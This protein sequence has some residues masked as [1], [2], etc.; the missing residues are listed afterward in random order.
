MV[1][2]PLH[3]GR[4]P[5]MTQRRHSPAVAHRAYATFWFFEHPA[6]ADMMPFHVGSA[7]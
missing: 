2:F 5:Y 7:A 1:K 4:R 6:Y 3:R